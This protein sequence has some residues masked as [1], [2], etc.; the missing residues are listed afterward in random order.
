MRGGD[1]LS[2]SD[3]SLDATV[4]DIKTQYAQRVG[5]GVDKI[6]LLLNKKPATDLKAL[7]DLNITKD[8]D[9]SAMLMGVASSDQIPMTASIDSTPLTSNDDKMEIDSEA[10]HPGSEKAQMQAEEAGTMAAPGND[11]KDMLNTTEFW[12][13]L[14]G[15]LAQRLRDEGEAARL[16][17]LFKSAWTAS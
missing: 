17:I 3:V 12:S 15:F 13:D 7:R 9:M 14:Q 5:L 8:V 6:K 16:A 10:H 11:A 4:H 2:L 1:V